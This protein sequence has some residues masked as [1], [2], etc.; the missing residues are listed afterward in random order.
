MYLVLLFYFIEALDVNYYGIG[1][2]HKCFFWGGEEL[3]PES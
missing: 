2:P 1:R 3:V